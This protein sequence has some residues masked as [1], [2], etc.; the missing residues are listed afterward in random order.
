[1]EDKKIIL[2]VDWGSQPSRAVVGFCKINK[3]PFELL[4]IRVGRA[5]HLTQE[6][7]Q[8]NPNKQVPAMKEI[9]TKTGEEWNLSESHAIL[10]YLAQTRNVA[11]HWYPK[12][13]IKRCEV[14]QYLDWHQNYLR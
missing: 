5:Q 11:D 2:Y 7:A 4:E 1:M 12:D 10:R 9:N 3:I 8:I 13:I 14:D 6:F